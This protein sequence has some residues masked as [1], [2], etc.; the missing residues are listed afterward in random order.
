M[1]SGNRI[2]WQTV[3]QGI[4]R[5]GGHARLHTSR[6]APA[7]GSNDDLQD[8]VSVVREHYSLIN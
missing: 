7:N 4:Q 6:A 3:A 2:T 5:L 1:E 8:F